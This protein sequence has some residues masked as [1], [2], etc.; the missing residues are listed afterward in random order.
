MNGSEDVR[1]YLIGNKAEMEDERE[2]SFERAVKFANQNGIHM[3][4]ETSAKTG[5]NVEEVF[6]IGGKEIF[7]KV[8]KDEEIQ[9]QEE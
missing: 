5:Y 1:I 4:F 3:V 6:S 8:K 2:V 7:Q 9:Q